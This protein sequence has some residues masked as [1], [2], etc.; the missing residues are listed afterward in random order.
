MGRNWLSDG[1]NGRLKPMA[2]RR[3][4]IFWTVGSLSATGTHD[5]RAHISLTQKLAAALMVVEELRGAIKMSRDDARYLTAD[6][7]ASLWQF[8]HAV[9]HAHG[10]SDHFTNLYPMLIAEHREK[11]AKVDVPRIAKSRRVEKKWSEFTAAIATGKKPLT[12][13]QSRWPKRKIRNRRSKP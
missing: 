9:A 5:A 1:H 8:D 10:G 2:S 11:T 4:E 3:R 13:K 6:Q 12:G 7:F